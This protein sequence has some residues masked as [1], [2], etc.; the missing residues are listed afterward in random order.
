MERALVAIADGADVHV[1]ATGIDINWVGLACSEAANFVSRHSP[2]RNILIKTSTAGGRHALHEVSPSF[3]DSLI[4]HFRKAFPGIRIILAD[5]PA[6]VSYISESQRLGWKSIADHHGVEVVDLNE[7]IGDPVIPGWRISRLFLEA[8]VIINITRAKTHRRFGVSLAEKALLGAIVPDRPGHPKLVGR[9][10]EVVW[11]M[12]ELERI[13][14]PLYSIIDGSP[15]VEGE[16]PL[17]GT[18]APSNFAVYGEGCFIPDL[19]AIVEMGFDPLLVPS[20]CRPVAPIGSPSS[21]ST[22]AQKRLTSYDFLPSVSCSWLHR[23]L[24]HTKHRQHKYLNL[25]TGARECW[26][27]TI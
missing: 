25:L 20:T 10:A 4:T 26:P 18:I 3:L 17:A 19:H 24:L 9:H 7:T 8:D 1:S 2:C 15:G 11:L 13:S 6:Y 14:P 27:T 22:W 12:A 5:G 23:S 21:T 16:G